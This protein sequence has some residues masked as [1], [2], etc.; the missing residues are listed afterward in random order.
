MISFLVGAFLFA[1]SGENIAFYDAMFDASHT[2]AEQVAIIELVMEDKPEGATEFFAKALSN[3]TMIYHRQ[4]DKN[5]INAADRAAVLLSR[6]LGEAEY[7][8]AGPGLWY[9][10][11]GFKNGQ[12][13][14]LAKAAA[15]EALGRIK[16]IEFLPQVVRTLN[17]LNAFRPSDRESQIRNERVAY[18]AIL[19]LEY[20]AEPDG[21]IPVFMASVGWYTIRVRRQA[22]D[23][24]SRILE[25]P[26]DLLA[27]IVGRTS[28]VGISDHILPV[29]VKY[30]ALRVADSSN[31]PDSGKSKVAVV[32]LAQGHLVKAAPGLPDVVQATMRKLALNMILR[33]GCEDEAVFGLIDRSYKEGAHDERLAALNALASLNTE[34]SARIMSGYLRE[35]HTRRVAGA[36]TQRQK[37]EEDAYVRSII[38]SLGNIGSTGRNY[39][40]SS[41]RLITNTGVWTSYVQGLAREALQKVGS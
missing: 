16:A 9:I 40:P 21:F 34:D 28:Y 24:L 11:Q 31:A 10:V 27:D 35:L 39:S 15:L 1:Q 37:Q 18:G 4:S 32:A 6:S 13:T 7:K 8:E 36:G 38:V 29:D 12:D 23:S 17:D 14:P 3:L 30:E 26:S 22:S 20:F 5:E 2:I 25:D 41:L 19:G 33:Y